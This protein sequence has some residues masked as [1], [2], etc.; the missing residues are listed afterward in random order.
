MV[1]RKG[2]EPPL[3][4]READFKSAA[5]TI[6]PPGHLSQGNPSMRSKRDNQKLNYISI[7][8]H[9]KRAPKR[10]PF[11]LHQYLSLKSYYFFILSTSA[12]AP[13]KA[14]EA[15]TSFTASP[16]MNGHNPQRRVFSNEADK[17]I[18][19]QGNPNT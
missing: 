5:S 9:K 1:P 13:G 19:N 3:S 8:G 18:I 4:C 17:L 7:E 15:S 6:P 12:H 16:G 2:L 14:K 11:S 10:M